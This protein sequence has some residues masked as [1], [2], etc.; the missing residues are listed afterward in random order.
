MNIPQ[1]RI[2]N[3]ALLYSSISENERQKWA[4][5]INQPLLGPAEINDYTSRFKSAWATYENQILESMVNLYDI[6]F[7]KNIIDVYVSPWNKSISNPLIVNPSRPPEIQI[8]TLTHE[9][10]HV[11]FTDNTSFSMH[12]SGQTIKLTDKWRGLFGGDLEWK[13]LVHIP[14]H[15]GLKAIFLDALNEPKR[16]ERDIL[17]HQQNPAYKKAWDYLGEHDYKAINKQLKDLYIQ[18]AEAKKF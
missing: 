10:L 9:L 4:D 18:M 14:V 12:D 11:L 6:E 13:T 1:I 5:S 3:S 2:Q 8:E 16:L 15:A 17:R 7:K